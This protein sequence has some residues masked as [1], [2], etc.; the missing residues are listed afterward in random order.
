MWRSRYSEMFVSTYIPTYEGNS[1][2]KSLHNYRCNFC[3]I[4]E[5]RFCHVISF[6]CITI[7]EIGNANSQVSKPNVWSIG[8]R[9]S[10]AFLLVVSTQIARITSPRCKIKNKMSQ[11][12]LWGAVFSSVPVHQ[13]R[14][15][16]FQTFALPLHVRPTFLIGNWFAN[17]GVMMCGKVN[18]IVVKLVDSTARDIRPVTPKELILLHSTRKNLGFLSMH[19]TWTELLLTLND[20]GAT[21]FCVA[22]TARPGTSYDLTFAALGKKRKNAATDVRFKS[23]LLVCPLKVP[24][25]ALD[26]LQ[27]FGVR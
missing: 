25:S 19:N 22:P 10:S 9:N 21:H 7:F 15:S 5:V 17:L 16:H 26:W 20:S 8:F 23:G 3:F 11:Q 18:T 12:L 4:F 24:T 14:D 2:R 1:L 6:I 27:T 13:D